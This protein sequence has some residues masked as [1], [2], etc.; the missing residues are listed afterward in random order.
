MSLEEKF[1]VWTHDEMSEAAVKRSHFLRN[2]IGFSPTYMNRY[3]LIRDLF[4][5]RVTLYGQ[6]F[7]TIVLDFQHQNDG[8]L[9]RCFPV[10]VT[11]RNDHLDS[12]DRC[13]LPL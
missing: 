7:C 11:V 10:C 4:D 1:E 8:V 12:R 9:G 5:Q 3:V 6:T 13:S 2:S